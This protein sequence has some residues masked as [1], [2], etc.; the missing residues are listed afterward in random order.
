MSKK[1]IYF[2]GIKFYNYGFDDLMKKLDKGGVLV[3]PAASALT[4]INKNKNYYSSLK[5]SDIAIFDSGLF[6]ILIRIF[7][8]KKV[9][10]LSGY[11]FLKQ[12]LNYK[13]SKNKKILLIN[14][15]KLDGEINKNLLFK[16]N[17]K[18]VSCYTAPLYKKEIVDRKLLKII[19]KKK[20]DYIIINIGG[21]IQ[22]Q[23]G[24]FI[25]K[26]IKQ[27]ISIICTGAAIA[28]ITKRQA[29]IN[30]YVDK[31]Y[32][33]WLWRIIYNPKLFFFRT[34]KSLML[35]KHFIKTN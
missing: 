1:I 24:I 27:K 35:I 5:S 18:K 10:K 34:F 22:E 26:N 4:Q 23:L 2:K 9:K 6:C 14:P 13:Q 8:K 33:G 3:A 11:F 7:L 25:K 19:K 15:T 21:I 29:P 16:N 17:F 32:L 31:F 28:F 30:D 12:F 20:Y